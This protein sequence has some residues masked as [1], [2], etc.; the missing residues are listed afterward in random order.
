M[1]PDSTITDLAEAG[2]GRGMGGH[3]EVFK[4]LCAMDGVEIYSEFLICFVCFVGSCSGTG[5]KGTGKRP[6]CEQRSVA[7]EGMVLERRRE[8]RK[9]ITVIA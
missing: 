1:I 9:R 8:G 5:L 4:D 3:S 7:V 6:V 2:K